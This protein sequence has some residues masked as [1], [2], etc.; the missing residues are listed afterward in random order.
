MWQFVIQ[1]NR[2][3]IG[4]SSIYSIL[5]SNQSSKLLVFL[6]VSTS[7][8]TLNFI[9]IKTKYSPSFCHLVKK[10]DFH[11]R[12]FQSK[13]CRLV[14]Q[15]LSS[16]SIFGQIRRKGDLVTKMTNFE[17]KNS[18]KNPSNIGLSLSVCW[19]FRWFKHFVITKSDWR[20]L[21]K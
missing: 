7:R 21:S 11:N 19:Y 17:T 20:F 8:S 2:S 1:D 3:V 4:S 13:I 10:R 6:V 14:I 9:V 5:W 18:V 12:K 16:F 15:F